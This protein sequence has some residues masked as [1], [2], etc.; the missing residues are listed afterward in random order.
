MHIGTQV[1]TVTV[2]G[3]A[4][5]LNTEDATVGNAFQAQQIQQLPI[6]SRNVVDL[7]E[8]CSRVSAISATAPISTSTKTPAAEL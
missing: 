6:E 5:T 8:V 3:Q 2:T 7:L 1:N 4:Q